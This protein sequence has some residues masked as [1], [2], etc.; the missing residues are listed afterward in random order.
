M[1]RQLFAIVLGGLSLASCSSDD[2]TIITDP[3]IDVPANYSFERNDNNTVSYSGQTTR[4]EMTS[5]ILGHFKDF[6]N[7]TEDMLKNM[8]ANENNPFSEA[9][10]NESSKSV[11]SKVAASNLYFSTNTVESNEIRADFDSYISAQMNEVKAARNQVAAPGVAGQ[12]ADGDAIRYV[13][14]EGLEM[15]QAFAKGLIGALVVD[16]MLNNY[17]V[18]AVLDAGENRANNEAGI[19]EEG[20]SYTTMEHKWDEAYGY[21]YGDPS[22]PSENPNAAL[23]DNSDNL[24]FKY[25]GRVDGDED[26]AGIA[27]EIFEAFKTGRAAIVAGDYELRDQQVD[28]IQENVSKIVGIRA[29]Y[30][31]QAGKAALAEGQYGPAFHDLSEG[32]GFIYSLRFTHNPETGAPYVSKASVDNY[33][34]QILD[35]NGFWEVTPET[36]DAISEEIATA[37]GFTV[38]E[39]L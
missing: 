25:L 20:K 6:D 39:A 26:F 10:L 13:N 27:D 34:E 2:D 21:L 15:D 3:E 24:L 38:N 37:F 29:V 1:K 18:E 11:K 9:A 23:Q 22:I 12:I 4:L 36:L 35:G 7:A 28:I 17:L 19:T 5:E 31:L 14:V 8:F 33:L 16:Q 32:Y 30:Y